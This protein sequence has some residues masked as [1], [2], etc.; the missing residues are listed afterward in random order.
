P[1]TSR[2]TGSRRIRTGCRCRACTRTDHRTA[3]RPSRTAG[4]RPTGRLRSAAA[5]VAPGP[6][7]EPEREAAARAAQ[8]AAPVAVQW[9][10]ARGA[11]LQVETDRGLHHRARR[12]RRDHTDPE[13]LATEVRV[14]LAQCRSR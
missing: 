10:A 13:A 8:V 3:S 4:C 11:L 12:R 5:A 2:T 14:A 9:A 1:T 7:P 6:A